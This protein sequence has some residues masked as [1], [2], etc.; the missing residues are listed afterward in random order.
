MAGKLLIDAHYTD[1]TR[2]AVI[3]EDGRLENFEA[4]YSK[5]RPIKGNIY[6]AKIIRIEPSLQAAFIDYGAEKNGFLP[7]TEIHYDYFNQNVLKSLE[8]E[9]TESETEE[10][11]NDQTRHF[12]RQPKIQE[13]ITTKQ[14]ILVQA[15]KEIRGNKCAFFT[16]FINLLGK[17]CVLTPN[18]P[19]GRK[20]MV[21]KRIAP[22][23]KERLKEILGE[24]NIPEGMSCVIRSTGA[25]RTKQEIKRDMDYLCRLWEEI[26]GKVT[27]SVPPKLIH[28]EGNIIQRSIRDLY[29]RTMDGVVIQGD[30]AFEEARAF[31][32]TYTPSQVKKIEKYDDSK[33]P[34]FNKYD[35]EDK[36]G[37][38]LESTISLPSGGTII[39]NTTE[40]LTAID[41][42]SAK[43]KN[44]R[45]IEVTA[46][47]TNLE[48]AREICRQ[49]RL[50]DIGG[51]IVIDFIDMEDSKSQERVEKAMHIALKRD[52][53]N[54][55]C[56]KISQFGLM[57]LSR[58][59]LRSNLTDTVF[60][61]C[62]H[63]SGSGRIL[64]NETV[65]L[66]VMRNIE[67]FLAKKIARS[68]VVEVAPGIDLF[69]LNRKRN[70]LIEMEKRHGTSIEIVRNKAMS[71]QEN[72]IRVVEYSN[73]ELIEKKKA[74]NINVKT[75]VKQ[76]SS[77]I[78]L[79]GIGTEKTT[80]PENIPQE[81][82]TNTEKPA[83]VAVP[84]IEV[85]QPSVEVATQIPEVGTEKPNDTPEKE[86]PRVLADIAI[87]SLDAPKKELAGI[88]VPGRAR[89]GVEAPRLAFAETSAANV[90]K[91][92]LSF[93]ERNP[94]DIIAQAI[95]SS[96][97]FASE[98]KIFAPAK[99]SSI[100]VPNK[101][102]KKKTTPITQS[103]S[104]NEAKVE[105][106]PSSEDVAKADAE[107]AN[108]NTKKNWLRKIFE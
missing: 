92:R 23:E 61:K 38:I 16:T 89:A 78:K 103:G 80:E 51:L 77:D 84:N 101:P 69:I 21:S 8:L 68:V 57:E 62:N 33:A 14:V 22:E 1:E 10:E 29:Q 19:S 26:K 17:Y 31:M 65:A 94:S 6:L 58:Q 66:S 25:K 52:L 11:N 47:K 99:R 86:R 76:S 74:R 53:S 67:N 3:G 36:I 87:P 108:T 20:N 27:D 46:L 71:A 91:P 63:C 106:T 12:K 13:V 104:N 32:K 50:R 4:E 2:I 60:V 54:T 59:R 98:G 18:P 79:P 35:V 96:N 97:A 75:K 107:P 55:Q 95:S 93:L 5:K 28:E 40:A 7:L 49:I 15:E 39:I 43:S 90:L 102:V 34:L 44:G 82:E 83:D 37:K 73:D 64:S 70:L 30:E 9:N 45:D 72:K 42:N 24:L 88:A 81:A 41:V 105:N 100:N 56:G 48:A 85:E